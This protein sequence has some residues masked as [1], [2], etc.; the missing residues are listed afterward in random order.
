MSK[1]KKRAGDY[2]YLWQRNGR[3]WVQ[4]A[5]PAALQ[6]RLGKRAIQISLGTS[7]VTEARQK[8]WKHVHSIK[9]TFERAL[10]N[11]DMTADEIEQI[12]QA[13]YQ[14]I[15]SVERMDTG[16]DIDTD[17]NEAIS[18]LAE[19]LK[20]VGEAVSLPDGEVVMPGD[21]AIDRFEK[22]T[23]IVLSKENRRDFKASIIR[24]QINAFDTILKRR[25]GLE[26]DPIP[27]FNRA[28]NATRVVTAQPSREIQFGDAMTE[29]LAIK[30]PGWA[31]KTRDHQQDRALARAVRAEQPEDLPLLYL[32]AQI[33]HREGVAEIARKV[34]EGD[35][36]WH[37]A[38]LA[39][40]TGPCQDG[41]DDAG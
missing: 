12:A 9:A 24:A 2:R 6:R 28:S 32:D 38:I 33:V 31:H 41:P 14:R 5:V 34:G 29:Y 30:S 40:K 4:V 25:R 26:A 15:A 39:R 1:G 36:G 37:A 17:L 13:E 8:R 18:H 21:P 10:T 35:A 23:G 7:D 11:E 16:G 19:D 22:E 27:I 20:S 3:F